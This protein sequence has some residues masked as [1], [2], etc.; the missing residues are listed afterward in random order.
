MEVG[1]VEGCHKR[2]GALVGSLGRSTHREPK[3]NRNEETHFGEQR[4]VHVRSVSGTLIAK[5][6]FFDRSNVI[7]GTR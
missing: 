1:L 3:E 7:T 4:H 2:E 5:A 6:S